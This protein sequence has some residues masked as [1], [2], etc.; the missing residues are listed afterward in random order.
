[1]RRVYLTIGCLWLVC[2]S[3][4][5]FGALKATDLADREAVILHSAYI[6]DVAYLTT[7]SATLADEKARGTLQ[8]LPHYYAALAA[9]KAAE[10]D[11]DIELRV[12]VLLD[13]CVDEARAA[14]K[15]DP[16]FAES[17]ALAGACHGLAAE[18]QPLS[19]IISGNFS[20]RELKKALAM[21]PENPRVLMLHA[22]TQ[23]RR[24]SDRTRV[25]EAEANLRKALQM[26]ET[27]AHDVAPG[28]PTWGEVETNRW[29]AKVA[30]MRDRPAIARDFLER[31]LLL[32]PQW[33][34]AQSQLA[35]LQR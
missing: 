28:F 31:A 4:T 27:F 25:R 3:Q 35:R 5:V 10:L 24:Y 7:L 11:E 30:L 17:L 26:F 2:T 1:M 33:Q 21:A 15:I 14:L 19:S 9:Y 20:A 18:R 16:E 8:A 32:A 34:A 23:L 6:A 22:S 12:G 29:L 13:R